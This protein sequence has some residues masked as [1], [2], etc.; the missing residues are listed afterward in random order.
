MTLPIRPP[1]PPMEALPVEE[2]PA[3][4]G[5][6][7]EPKWDGFRCIAFRDGDEVQLQSK[8]GKPLARY[9]PD[10]AAALLQLEAKRFV[11]DGEIVVP[12]G[13]GLSFEELQL[14][15]HPAASRVKKLAAAKPALYV[16]FDVLV[17]DRA[18][19]LTGRVLAERRPLLEKFAAKF[20]GDAS[21]A[22][23]K[24]SPATTNR[25]RALQWFKA[26]GIGLDGVSPNAPI[27]PTP[28]ASAPPCRR[29]RTSAPR[30]ALSRGSATQPRH[31]LSARCCWGCTTMPACSTTWDLHQA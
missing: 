13:K 2:I 24:L 19:L 9:F 12:V 23:L 20:I 1:F 25:D 28:R 14:R 31:A 22:R 18:T 17:D 16:L 6:Q 8:A 21:P 30:I 3:G 15:L 29:S 27:C 11:L 10:V 4:P 26:R 5:W 7:Y